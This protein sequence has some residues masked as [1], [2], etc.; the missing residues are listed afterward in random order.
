MKSHK[1]EWPVR[2]TVQLIQYSTVFVAWMMEH[3]GSLQDVKGHDMLHLI[4]NVQQ[5]V[6]M[7]HRRRLPTLKCLQVCQNLKWQH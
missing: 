5:G 3:L 6:T 2:S 4:L 1:C 7:C